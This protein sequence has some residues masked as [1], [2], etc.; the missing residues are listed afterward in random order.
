MPWWW[1]YIFQSRSVCLLV[2]TNRT[3]GESQ[4]LV[5]S[6]AICNLLF[7]SSW[8][9]VKSGKWKRRLR[10]EKNDFSTIKS[11]CNHWYFHNTQP[12]RPTKADRPP[13]QSNLD[14]PP[15]QN[16]LTSVEQCKLYQSPWDFLYID[17]T[18]CWGSYTKSMLS[19]SGHGT[20]P[21][22]S[23]VEFGMN[24]WSMDGRQS[25]LFVHCQV[26]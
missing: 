24:E 17:E 16:T 10:K 14:L 5:H 15:Y 3:K 4:L 19:P 8:V 11:I 6:T 20:V 23:S 7:C 13:R 25:M 21:L 26:D 18:S 22:V 2:G 1:T 9:L 12:P